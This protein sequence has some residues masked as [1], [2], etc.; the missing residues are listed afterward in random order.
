MSLI[1]SIII[2]L[3]MHTVVCVSIHNVCAWWK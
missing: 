1:Q 3:H 2:M